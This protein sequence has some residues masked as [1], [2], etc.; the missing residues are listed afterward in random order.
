MANANKCPNCGNSRSTVFWECLKCTHR[1]CGVCGEGGY[2]D[3]CPRCDGDG[4][5]IGRIG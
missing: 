3:V 5:K 4:R 1:F 2:G